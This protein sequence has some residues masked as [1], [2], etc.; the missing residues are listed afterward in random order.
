MGKTAKQPAKQQSPKKSTQKHRR[1]KRATRRILPWILILVFAI[2]GITAYT[3]H[4]NPNLW[5]S[6]TNWVSNTFSSSNIVMPKGETAI[7]FI[8][9]GQGNAVLIQTAG[10]TMLIDGGDNGLGERV[11]TYLR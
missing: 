2:A 7:H 3:L 10:G 1:K 4:R 8:D 6:I 5:E 11:L 9:V